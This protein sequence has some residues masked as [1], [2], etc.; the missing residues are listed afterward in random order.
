VKLG[1][2]SGDYVQVL[3]GIKEGEKIVI[4]SQFLIDSESNL[5]AAIGQMSGH[6]GMDMSKG[7]EG[8]SLKGA[9][10]KDQTMKGH[11]GMDMPKSATDGDKGGESHG[12]QDSTHHHMQD[13]N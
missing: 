10:P 9:D 5:K 1:V 13:M 6:A 2:Q 4:S 3:D 8:Q 7:T 11:E 12:A